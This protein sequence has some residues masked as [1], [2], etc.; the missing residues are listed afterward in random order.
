MVNKYQAG[1]KKNTS[2]Y[3]RWWFSGLRYIGDYVVL[4]Y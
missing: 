1:P 4:V 2:S 3:R